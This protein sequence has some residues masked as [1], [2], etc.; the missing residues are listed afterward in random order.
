MKDRDIEKLIDELNAGQ[1]ADR[2]SQIC[3]SETVEFLPVRMGDPPRSFPFYFIKKTSGIYVGAV[4][5]WTNDLH[6]FIKPEHRKKG[7]LYNALNETILPYL[8]QQGR[9][10]QTLS[11]RNEE[12]A[13]CFDRLGFTRATGAPRIDAMHAEKDLSVYATVPKIEPL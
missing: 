9:Y 5:D 7:H 8:F 10:V 4:L 11:Y 2:E 6:V 13:K 1:L 3:L 12:V